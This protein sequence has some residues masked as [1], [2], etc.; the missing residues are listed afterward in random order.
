MKV[1]VCSKFRDFFF[2]KKEKFPLSMNFGRISTS[3]CKGKLQKMGVLYTHSPKSHGPFPKLPKIL[4]SI[5]PSI[6]LQPAGDRWSPAGPRPL[7]RGRQ[8]LVARLLVTNGRG[9]VAAGRPMTGLAVTGPRPLVAGS[10]ATRG[11]RPPIRGPGSAGD[12]RS[13]AGHKST[14]GPIELSP[15]FWIFFSSCLPLFAQVVNSC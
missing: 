13:L 5:R 7:I 2:L 1:Q 11:R 15:F 3:K 4:I 10:S 12:Q 6:D 8:L 9:L 14:P